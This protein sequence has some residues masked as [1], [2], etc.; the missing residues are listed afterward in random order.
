MFPATLEQIE[1]GEV[2]K[3]SGAKCKDLHEW[4]LSVLLHS[5]TCALH[6]SSLASGARMRDRRGRPVWKSGRSG[7]L[8]SGSGEEVPRVGASCVRK[9]S[10]VGILPMKDPFLF[11]A[12]RVGSGAWLQASP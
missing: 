11:S 5:E 7:A 3:R 1:S 10:V 8:G 6:D 4:R 9:R 12:I 2:K